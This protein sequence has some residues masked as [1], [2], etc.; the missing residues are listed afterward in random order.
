MVD[1]LSAPV[2]GGS[3]TSLT[4]AIDYSQGRKHCAD[5]VHEVC[6]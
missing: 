6:S 3:H 4:A 1:L 5:L 2:T